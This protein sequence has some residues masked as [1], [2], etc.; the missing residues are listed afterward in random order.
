MPVGLSSGRR[1]ARLALRGLPEAEPETGLS[2]TL[3]VGVRRPPD[4][5]DYADAD[6]L[7]SVPPLLW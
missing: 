3:A 7:Y 1:A 5:P 6:D 2:P 4:S